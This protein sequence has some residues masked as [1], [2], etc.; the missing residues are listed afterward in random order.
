[1]NLSPLVS[2]SCGIVKG[3]DK[4]I[5]VTRGICDNEYNSMSEAVAA[6]K[7]KENLYKAKLDLI[8]GKVLKSYQFSGSELVLFFGNDLYAVI[9]PG[10]N[11]I[12][13]DVVPSKPRV[14]VILGEQD[15][16]LELPS[17]TK[18]VWD[19]KMVLDNFIGKQIAVSPSDQVLFVFARDGAEFLI[20]FYVEYDNPHKQLLC[21][22][23]A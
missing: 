10:Q 8:N 13:L 12:N 2:V 9:S 11:A 17:G 16:Y 15:V 22:S 14:D 20:T 1:M 3:M 7:Q 4:I 23:Q 21:I 19:W 6:A 5:R 18:I